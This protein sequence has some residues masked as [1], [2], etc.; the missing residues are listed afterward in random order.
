MLI[1]NKCRKESSSGG[2]AR[3]IKIIDGKRASRSAM[4]VKDCA[5][6]FVIH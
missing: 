4:Q 5:V 6:Q 1:Q 2:G 3:V